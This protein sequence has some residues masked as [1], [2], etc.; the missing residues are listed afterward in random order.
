MAEEPAYRVALLSVHPE[1]A[2]ALLAGTKTVEF[3]KRPLAA[4][5][6]HVAIYATQPVGR[7]V[8]I[9]S[10]EEQV[11]GNPHQLWR[12]FK[13]VAGISRPKFFEYYEGHHEG[14]GI[15]VRELASFDEAFTLEDAFGISRP[16]QS[17]Q[18]FSS[19]QTHV[20]LS[21]ALV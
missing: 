1:F 6:T 10:I 8:G 17:F 3:R 2:D 13:H 5:V 20:A 14:V 18:Y 12:R 19:G 21:G 4:D 7:V 16:P 9:F 11:K 15:R